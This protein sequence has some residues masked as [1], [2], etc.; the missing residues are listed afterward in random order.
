MFIYL[1]W[2]KQR[3]DVWLHLVYANDTDA[4]VERARQADMHPDT[5]YWVEQRAVIG[6]KH[7]NPTA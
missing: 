1:I 4:Q 6:Y 5:C 2:A 7:G 3:L